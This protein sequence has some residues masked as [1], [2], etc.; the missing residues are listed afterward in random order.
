MFPERLGQSRRV[1]DHEVR[2]MG[3]GL[4]PSNAFLEIYDHQRRL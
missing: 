4:P 1:F 3:G 2:R